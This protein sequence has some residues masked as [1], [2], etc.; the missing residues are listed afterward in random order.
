V[1]VPDNLYIGVIAQNC[2][3]MNPCEGSGSGK[4]KHGHNFTKV[5]FVPPV[6]N[7]IEEF[8]NS[9]SHT[10]YCEN[11]QIRDFYLH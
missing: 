6:E 9:K 11:G 7:G 4:D 2:L 5:S 1:V 8:C 10:Q 3:G